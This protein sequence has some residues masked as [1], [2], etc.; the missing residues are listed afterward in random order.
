MRISISGLP[1]AGTTTVSKKLAKK[2][3]YKHIDVGQIFR[4][5]ALEHKMSL[6]D[7]ENYVLKHL[8]ED[9]KIDQR[10]MDY[11]RENKDIIL[12]GRL[13]GWMTKRNKIP[14]FKVWFSAPKKIRAERIAQREKISFPEALKD[15]NLREAA[16][17]Q[18]YK[19][20]YKIDI[21]D[22]SIYDLRVDSARKT[23]EEI[24]NLILDKIKN[25]SNKDF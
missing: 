13:T 18:R 14:C 10:V 23:P 24:V 15:I 7:F 12:E 16:I 11:A 19:N 2:L 3:N 25:G 1:G 9:R 4:Q 22:L 21:D 8:E 20:C 17:R 5:A 6:F